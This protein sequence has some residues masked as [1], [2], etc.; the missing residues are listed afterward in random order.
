MEKYR[1]L[2]KKLAGLFVAVL[3]GSGG[4]IGPARA[5]QGTV[6]PAAAVAVYVLVTGQRLALQM[7]EGAKAVASEGALLTKAGVVSVVVREGKVEVLALA[8]GVTWLTVPATDGAAAAHALLVVG[9][10]Q[11]DAQAQ[12]ERLRAAQSGL[13]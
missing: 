4:A 12:F 11:A 13:R 1:P 10:D 7:R 5:Q 8:P 9:K 6:Q 2:S 3:M